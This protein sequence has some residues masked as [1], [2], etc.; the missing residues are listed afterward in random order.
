M[1]L[2][3]ILGAVLSLFVAAAPAL[4]QSPGA[5]GLWLVAKKDGAVEVYPCGAQLCGRLVWLKEPLD[6]EGSPKRDHRND[7]E[8]LKS[9]PICGLELMTGFTQ[10]SPTEWTGG[11]IYSPDDG[12][13]YRAQMKLDGPDRLSLRGYVGIPLLG[14]SEIWTRLPPDAP[15]CKLP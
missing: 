3:L 13:T 12:N 14:R 5:V 9:R 8:R 4:A 2:P 11:R 6:T 7:D 10:E 15:R 1:R